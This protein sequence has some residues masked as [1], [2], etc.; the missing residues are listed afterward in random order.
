MSRDLRTLAANLTGADTAELE[1]ALARTRAGYARIGFF[2]DRRRADSRAYFAV[3]DELAS[4]RAATALST[5]RSSSPAE[6]REEQ[7]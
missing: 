7:S 3:V 2:P 6:V 1:R 4:R 5:S